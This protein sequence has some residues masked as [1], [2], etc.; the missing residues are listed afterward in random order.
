MI[1]VFN[2]NGIGI[3]V[4]GRS[5]SGHSAGRSKTIWISN[6]PNAFSISTIPAWFYWDGV[7]IVM[8]TFVDGPQVVREPARPAALRKNPNVAITVDTEGFPPHVLL[9]GGRHQ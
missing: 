1:S 5:N 7:E 8:A 3:R 4:E 6:W 2:K 9:I